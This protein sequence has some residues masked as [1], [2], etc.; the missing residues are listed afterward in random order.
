MIGTARSS[1]SPAAGRRSATVIVRRAVPALSLALSL[2]AGAA[3]C[4]SS[5]AGD[6]GG[7]TGSTTGPAAASSPAAVATM[8]VA[9]AVPPTTVVAAPD[10]SAGRTCAAGGTCRV[11]D[12]GPAGGLVFSVS[13]QPVDAAS[14]IG[15]GGVYLEAAPA[16]TG[17]RPAWCVGSPTSTVYDTAVGSGAANT[18]VLL[19]CTDG[20]AVEAAAYAHA[21]F[22]DWFLPSKDELDLMYR[23]LRSATPSLGGFEDGPYWSSSQA[24]VNF[25]WAQMFADGRQGQTSRNA[26]SLYRTSGC[27]V[28]P[29]RAFSPLG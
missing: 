7:T 18:V 14:G 17:T 5:R 11:G 12:T 10:G 20:A 13:A 24:T 6:S 25:V 27:L 1:A 22:D 23:N 15:R 4:S 29:V 2:A 28:R 21:G 8:P 16:D 9:P 19:G 26:A 3:G